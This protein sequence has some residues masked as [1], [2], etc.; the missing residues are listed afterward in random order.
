MQSLPPDDA[1]V[2]SLLS[3]SYEYK[4]L[5]EEN[6][7]NFLHPII[8]RL[9]KDKFKDLDLINMFRISTWDKRSF[10]QHF[11]KIQNWLNSA[12]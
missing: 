10:K 8:A 9:M 3:S 6:R 7:I 5:K 11:N 1:K 4:A 12:V 2:K